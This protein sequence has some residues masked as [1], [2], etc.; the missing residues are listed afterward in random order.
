MSADRTSRAKARNLRTAGPK[1]V[2]RKNPGMG[3]VKKGSNAPS[4]AIKEREQKFMMEEAML[5][6]YKWVD[7]R[8]CC[9]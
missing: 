2:D 1:Q 5:V 9:R 6:L 7:F 3:I 8:L 4:Q